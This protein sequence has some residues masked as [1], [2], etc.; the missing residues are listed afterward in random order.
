VVAGVTVLPGVSNRAPD[1]RCSSKAQVSRDIGKTME[2]L[3]LRGRDISSNSSSISK[4][5]RMSTTSR[6]ATTKND[7]GPNCIPAR[8]SV[9]GRE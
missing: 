7:S 2:I 5:S 6:A 4:A 8:T 3:P 9:L 1:M